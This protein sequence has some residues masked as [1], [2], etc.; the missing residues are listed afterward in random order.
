MNIFFRKGKPEIFKDEN[1]VLRRRSNS[2]SVSQW[3]PVA[4]ASCG[5]PDVHALP[6][7]ALCT[8]DVGLNSAPR[9]ALGTGRRS[10]S[11]RDQG[12]ASR[13]SQGPGSHCPR[14][15]NL[16]IKASSSWDSFG[17]LFERFYLQ[18]R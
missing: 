11:H 5:H 3:F 12:A 2:L 15:P 14:F 1:L 10:V 17:S 16:C 6:I 18:S 8:S 7:T 4:R 13:P 9:A